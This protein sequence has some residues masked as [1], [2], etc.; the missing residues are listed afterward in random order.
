MKGLTCILLIPLLCSAQTKDTTY[1][2]QLI[3]MGSAFEITVVHHDKEYAGY[4][5]DS[6]I[7]E[8]TR[9]ENLIS[10]WKES[11]QTSELVKNA[12]KV[13]ISIDDEL[14]DL[15]KRSIKVSE[16]TNGAFDITFAGISPLYTFDGQERPLPAQDLIRAS[17][18]KIG[19]KDII[20]NK[21]KVLLARS[22]MKIGFGAIGK[23]YAAERAKALLQQM[24]IENGVVD[25]SGDL[26][27]WGTQPDGQAWKIGIVD[28]ED[29]SRFLVWL[30]ASNTS[31]VTSGNYEK[32]FT[33]GGKRYAHI[34]DPRTG[35]PT[36]GLKSVTIITPN[37]ELA[38]A[39][40]TSV[41][42]LGETEGLELINQLKGVE[43]LIINDNNQLVS[44]KGLQMNY[45]GY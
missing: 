36:T 5:I 20:L 24:G 8:I 29:E 44:S 18:A 1:S 14:Y 16:L 32:Y 21:D 3:L 40:A 41:F 22:G 38:D 27:A 2:R 15:I 33:C 37:A 23:G 35:Y 10:E 43:C 42:V 19:Y 11:S 13:P 30:D 6:A 39:L 7:T 4:C 25:A 9:I 31:I 45:T 26:I 34:I 12:G 28:P 17:I